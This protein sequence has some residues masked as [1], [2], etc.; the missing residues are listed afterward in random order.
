MPRKKRRADLLPGPP[1][2]TLAEVDRDGQDLLD[3]LPELD[4]VLIEDSE[5]EDLYYPLVDDVGDR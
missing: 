2:R 5:L 4:N 3:T 1:A